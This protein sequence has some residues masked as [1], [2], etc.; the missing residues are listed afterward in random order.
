MNAKVKKY[1]LW[2][3]LV[4]IGV[5]AGGWIRSNVPGASKLPTI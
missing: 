5:I 4:I 3:I 2:I 1:G